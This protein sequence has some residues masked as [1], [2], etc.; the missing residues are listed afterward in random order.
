MHTLFICIMVSYLSSLLKLNGFNSLLITGSILFCLT[1]FIEGLHWENVMYFIFG[2]FIQQLNL[3]FNQFV[4]PTFF[5]LIPVAL[6]SIFAINLE[7]STLSGVGLTFCMVSLLMGMFSYVPKFIKNMFLYLGRNSFS[8]L[9]FSP[10]FSILTKQY[11]AMFSFDFTHLLWTVF[12]LVLVIGLSLLLAFVC[13]K[14]RISRFIIGTN[15]Y[16]KFER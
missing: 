9:L 1:T 16:L 13:D 6:I 10:I 2:G 5:S 8:I 11:S 7:R 3:K 12:S 14:M 4:V 15:L